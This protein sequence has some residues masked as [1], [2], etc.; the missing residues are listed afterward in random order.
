MHMHMHKRFL[1]PSLQALNI[2]I[3]ACIALKLEHIKHNN[4]DKI[5]TKDMAEA[6]HYLRYQEIVRDNQR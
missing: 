2:C 1:D 4:L 6:L 5:S 3:P